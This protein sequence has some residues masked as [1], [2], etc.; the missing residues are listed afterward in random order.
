[1]MKAM[2]LEEF[3]QDLKLRD[4]EVPK[5]SDDEVLVKMKA[6]SICGTD[7]KIMAGKLDTV[8]LPLILGHEPTG[9]VVEVGKNVDLIKI[10]DRITVDF[11][12]TCGKCK[13][14]LAGSN[15]VCLESIK[16][17]GFELNGGFAEYLK[18]PAENAVK[19]PDNMSF[20]EAALI[21]DA[22]ATSVH[23]FTDRHQLVSGDKVLILGIGGLGVHG[24]QVAKAYGGIV[25][26]ADVDEQKLSLAKELGADYTCNTSEENLTEF[27]NKLTEGHGMDVVVEYVGL[28]K[29]S[30]LGLKCLRMGGTMIFLGYSPGTA[31]EVPS[32]EIALGERTITGSRAMNR[33]SMLEAIK[34]VSEGKV[35]P[36]IDSCFSLEEA[37][38]ALERLKNEGYRGRGL[39]AIDL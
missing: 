5:V 37:N 24:L 11:Y 2:V 7:L 31:F 36:Q 30:E 21:P 39:L 33:K 15:T 10:G 22:I 14:C 17:I 38:K 8:P 27:C 13:N 12:L 34:L 29:V 28:P 4:V 25:V 16:R 9:E 3:N 20:Q 26:A 32:M 23:A 18:L 1:M 6:C 35:K 19:I